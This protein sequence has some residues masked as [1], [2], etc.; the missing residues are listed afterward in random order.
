MDDFLKL[1]EGEE[2]PVIEEPKT[3]KHYQRGGRGRPEDRK[4]KVQHLWDNHREMLRLIALGHGNKDIAEIVGCTPA[5]VCNVRNSPICRQHLEVLQTARDSKTVDVAH[6]LLEDAPKSLKLLQEI[7]DGEH[8]AATST[9]AVVAQD[10]LSRAGFPKITKVEGNMTHGIVTEEVLA[11]VKA[12]R[13]GAVEADFSEESGEQSTAL[14][15]G[16]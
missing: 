13:A 3:R 14:V 9:R 4:Y 8:G 10:L 6:V 7:R 2:A 15:A 16:A 5:T 11:R 12:R 1:P